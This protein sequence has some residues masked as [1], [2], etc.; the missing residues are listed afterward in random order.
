MF[1]NSL[2]FN[3]N[4]YLNE[5]ASNN[6]EKKFNNSC[7]WRN[8]LNC[9]KFF[10]IKLK[11]NGIYKEDINNKNESHDPTIIFASKIVKITSISVWVIRTM[12]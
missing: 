7:I 3:L 8:F 5:I 1:E 4:Y 2:G 12:N 9:C 10:K 6:L 11:N